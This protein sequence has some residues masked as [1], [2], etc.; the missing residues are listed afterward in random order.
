[1]GKRNHVTADLRISAE[2]QLTNSRSFISQLEKII[3]QFDVGDKMSKQ[4]MSAQDQLKAY[5]KVLEKVHGKTLISDNELRDVEKIGDAVAALITKT[6]KLYSGFSASDWKKMSREYLAQI[7]AQEKQILKIKEEYQKKTGKIYD[8]EILNYDKILAKNKELKAQREQLAKSGV[9]DLANKQI[10]QLNQKLDAQKEKLEDIITLREKSAKAFQAAANKVAQ[11]NGFVDY[12]SLKSTKTLTDNQV[13]R[14]LGAEKYNQEK[15]N[16][17]E[18]LRI[19]K[20]IEQNENDINT[21]NE[22]AINIAKR[23]NLENVKDLNTLKEQY[24]LRKELLQTFSNDKARLALQYETE[25]T[26]RLREQQRIRD[27]MDDAKQA[28]INAQNAAIAGSKY[29]STQA[30]SASYTATNRAI[31]NLQGQLSE[32][33]IETIVDNATT[34]VEALLRQIDSE[35]EQSNNELGSLDDTNK[36]LATQSERAA[37]ELDITNAS[38]STI[39]NVN[40][41]TDKDGEATRQN[42]NNVTESITNALTEKGAT[43]STTAKATLSQ[44]EKSGSLEQIIQMVPSLGRPINDEDQA[45]SKKLHS[46]Q[47][48]FQDIFA[49]SEHAIDLLRSPLE[50]EEYQI[51]SKQS[52]DNLEHAKDLVNKI[53]SEVKHYKDSEMKSLKSKQEAITKH[54]TRGDILYDDDMAP[55]MKAGHTV[56]EYDILQ[57]RIEALQ[58]DIKIINQ[59]QNDYNVHFVQA[60]NI[61][62]DFNREL[63]QQD[64][65]TKKNIQTQKQH[66]QIVGEAG[67]K[68]Q[69][70]A[71]AIHKAAEQSRYLGSAFDDIKN[72]IGYFLSLN[73]IFD[74]VIRKTKEASS[75]I[76]ETDKDMVQIG[77]VLGKTSNDVW[78]NFDT[79]SKMATRLSTTTS[80]VTGAMKLFYQ[81]GLN[82][83]EVN[84][85]VEASAIAAALGESTMAEASETLTSILNSYNLTANDAIKVTDKISQVAI[86]SAADFE[87][88]STAIEKV[89]S[90]AAS[91]G[92][93]LDHMMG[94]LAKMIETTREAPSNIGTALK[95]IVAN[96]T[97]F[98][99]DPSG[100]TEAGSDINKVD[101]ALKS[102]G[103]SLTDTY[104]EVRDLGDVLDELGQQWEHLTRSQKSYLATQIAGTRQQSRFYAMMNDYDRTLELVEESQDSAGKSTEQFTLYQD[105]LTGATARLQNESQKLYANIT[106]EDGALKAWYNALTEILKIINKIGPG[107]TVAF[108][109]VGTGALKSFLNKINQ[110]SNKIKNTL[111]D[112]TSSESVAKA[113]QGLTPSVS[114]QLQNSVYGATGTNWIGKGAFKG[115]SKVLNLN[116]FESD[117]QTLLKLQSAIQEGNELESETIQGL[118]GSLKSKKIQTDLNSASNIA[119]LQTKTANTAGEVGQKV[120]IKATT[121]ALWAKAAATAAATM[122]ISLVIGVATTAITSLINLSKKSEEETLANARAN[123]QAASSLEEESASLQKTFKR[124]EELS[125]QVSLN[126]DEKEELLNINTD[127][128]SQ[129]PELIEGIDAEGQAYL[130]NTSYLRD[131]IK[132]KKIDAAQSKKDAANTQATALK[133]ASIVSNENMGGYLINSS[134]NLDE[135][136][137]DSVR[138]K[139]DLFTTAYNQTAGSL[140]YFGKGTERVESRLQYYLSNGFGTLE[141]NESQELLDDA[142]IETLINGIIGNATLNDDQRNNLRQTIINYQSYL[143]TVLAEEAK[144]ALNYAEGEKDLQLIEAG[145]EE[146]EEHVANELITSMQKGMIEGQQNSAENVTEFEQWLA[147]NK[148][149]YSTELSNA[150]IAAVK[151]GNSEKIL[152][153]YAQIEQAKKEGKS[154]IEIS[155]LYSELR[156]L[157]QYGDFATDGLD[158]NQR[159]TIRSNLNTLIANLATQDDKLIDDIIKNIGFEPQDGR[160]NN[161][162]NRILSRTSEDTKQQFVNGLQDLIDSGATEEEKISYISFFENLL[163]GSNEALIKDLN[164]LNFNDFLEVEAFKE[165]WSDEIATQ[166]KNQNIDGALAESIIATIVPDAEIIRSEVD[167]QLQASLNNMTSMNG[168]NFNETASNQTSWNDA[169]EAGFDSGAGYYG[170]GQFLLATTEM[171]SALDDNNESLEKNIKLLKESAMQDAT[172]GFE[173]IAEA[174][175]KIADI[176]AKKDSYASEALYEQDLETQEQ[177]IKNATKQITQASRQAKNAQELTKE[178]EKQQKLSKDLA[179]NAPFA[180]YLISVNNTIDGLKNYAEIYEKVKNNEL[181]QLDTLAL[182]CENLDLV[183]SAYWDASGQLRINE[184]AL[185]SLAEQEI[186]TAIAEGDITIAR[187][188]QLKASIDAT[189]TYKEAEVQELIGIAT[190]WGNLSTDQQQSLIDQETA[191]QT[192]LTATNKWTTSL[193]TFLGKAV[194]WWNKYWKST[195]GQEQTLDGNGST[196]DVS[197]T[198]LNGPNTTTGTMT[199]EEAKQKIQEQIDKIRELQGFLKKYQGNGG[200]LYDDINDMGKGSDGGSDDEYEG[201]IEK[202]EHFYNYLRQ[203]EELEAKINK[204]REKRNLID[205]TQNYYIDDLKEENELLRQQSILYGNYIDDEKEYLAELRSALTSAYSD[206]VYFTN[207]GLVQVKQTEFSINS[208]EE[209]ERYNAFSELLDEYQNEYNTMLENQN[210]LYSIQSTMVENINSMYDKML[211]RLNDVT[212]RL[213]YINSI[214]EHKV[215]M[216]FGSIDKLPLLSEQIKTTTDMLLYADDAVKRLEGDFATLT[217]LVSGSAFKDLLTWDETLQKFMVNNAKMNSETQAHYEA[218]GYNWEDIV[219]WVESVAAASQKVTDSLQE[220]NSQL[221]DAREALKDLLEERISTIDEIFEK[222]TDEMNKFYGIYES[223]IESLG[224][225]NDLFGVKSENLE[226]QFEYL[227]QTATHAKVLLADLKENN[228]MVL[229]TLMQDYGQYVDMIDG[230]AYINKM[231]IEESDSL[232]ESQRADLLQLYQ[233]YYDSNDQIEELNEK[234]YDYVSQIEELEREKRDAIID[235]KQQVHD[236]LMRLDQEEI[237]DLSEKYAKMNALDNEYYSKL[238]QRISDAR[239]ARSRLQDQQNL[240]QMQNRLSVLQQDNSGQYNSELVEL[241]RQINEQLQAQADQNIDLEMERIA[242]EQQQREEDR[243]MQI[244]QMENLLTFKDEN[245]WYWQATQ[246]IINEGSASIVGMLMNAKEVINNSQEQQY[247]TLE[248]LQD[249]AATAAAE[250]GQGGYVAENFRESLSEFVHTPLSA[251]DV[252][253]DDAA[254]QNADTIKNQ[255]AEG[256]SVFINTMKGLFEYLAIL[257]GKT[258]DKGYNTGNLSASGIYT[259]P[260]KEPPKPPVVTTPPPATNTSSGSGGTVGVGSRVKASSG[261]RIYT[262]STGSKGGSQYYANDPIYKVLQIIG[263]RALVR[264]H[265]L[266][267][268]YTGWFNLSDLTAYKKGG[269][270]DYTGPAWVDGTNTSPEAFLNAKQTALFETLRDALVKMPNINSGDGEAGDNI[271]IENLTIDVKELAD[272]DSIDKVV[273]TVKDSIYRDATSGNNMKINRR[274]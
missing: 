21:Q 118:I 208:E 12:N 15:Q 175:Q 212:E 174:Q 255:I 206:W 20:E 227:T 238:Q 23:Y 63:A 99:E 235:L 223:K 50:L 244:T 209:E 260:T 122:G 154:S 133:N 183:S 128:T 91:A 262:S 159:E 54:S 33:G 146:N 6:E 257:T 180:D 30:L 153:L 234:F 261:A 45:V 186:E 172:D 224:T 229:N 136:V 13:K 130:K 17:S 67:E 178:L 214:S 32:S 191:M 88:I 252:T 213:E 42:I 71:G 158:D 271:T 256:T 105:S 57:E 221:M 84:K 40:D 108:G 207:D 161:M 9:D 157:I 92:L 181:S 24:R 270:V 2:A 79:Y 119:E 43:V 149:A 62:R 166:L 169:M 173:K 25:L 233:L 264:H 103:I 196:D 199:G 258:T 102:I 248:E 167:K 273:K 190:Q 37:D 110:V 51:V 41:H 18:V 81:Q 1:M 143:R 11:D 200:G 239:D 82:T 218:Q 85:M 14:Q 148:D 150:I 59:I 49:E 210:T 61:T 265:K 211:Q 201:M 95:T 139:Y 226:K 176:E 232:T 36:K 151:G 230:V 163:T 184:E 251:L 123:L 138:E 86:V 121:A 155:E 107:M 4:L 46:L 97:Q 188:E 100:L 242:R 220:S 268:G 272:T 117:Y 185:K 38:S 5:N 98:K 187:L 197:S 237:D 28:G 35:I 217:D 104:G 193:K 147:E 74:T 145:L 170:N 52:I 64:A 205:A 78:K 89:A 215:T 16:L 135:D 132:Q 144:N 114:S 247:Q 241:Q 76:K 75:F 72:K 120:A 34:T 70:T 266:S 113:G 160:L 47:K 203:I 56:K 194:E 192:N 101:T 31:T 26:A 162:L 225:E 140:P 96:F 156:N 195:E 204:I 66:N 222:A 115:V 109:V 106:S 263:N 131:Y 177:I 165:K 127:L 152:D 202:L 250:L 253:L 94:Y 198:T 55:I 83:A 111:L 65:Q 29:N 116:K 27:A 77:L 189:A 44:A 231:A 8:K 245:G 216:N 267:S 134:L 87:E 90:S 228:Q 112:I 126:E 7:E 164:N 141:N 182:L 53:A 274:R 69:K 240:T 129:Y 168:I 249:K 142:Q 60:G 10:E 137:P 259:M 269:Y 243:Q 246:G 179:D 124:Y 22:Q 58:E 39:A 19:I 73:Y 236:E 3:D 219:S 171:T 48:Q 93:D 125:S 254:K 80:D 68:A